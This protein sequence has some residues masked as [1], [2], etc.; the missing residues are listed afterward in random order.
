MTPENPH[1]KS[2][3]VEVALDITPGTVVRVTIQVSSDN[4]PQVQVIASQPE[5]MHAAGPAEKPE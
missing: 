3:H 4:P 5:P 2:V 1:P